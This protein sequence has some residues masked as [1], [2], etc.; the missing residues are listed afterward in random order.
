MKL[1]ALRPAAIGVLG[2]AVFFGAVVALTWSSSSSNI[3]ASA[4][5]PTPTPTPS[6]NAVAKVIS[7][8]GDLIGGALSRGRLGD[9]L[10]ANTG[11]QFV[12]QQP[13][14]NLLSVGQFG[15]QIID[16]DLVRALGDPERDSFE[17]FA[18]GI[19]IENTAHYTNVSI[20]N[21]G[22][23]GQPAIVRA[24]GVDDLLDFINPS[25]QA[26]DFGLT[27][28]AQFNDVDLPV[29]ITTD[30]I[31]APKSNYVEV[32]T[33]V[34]NT[35]TTQTVETFFTEF[36]NG[37]GDLEIFQPG[38]G[39]GEVLVSLACGQCNVLAWNGE[40]DATGVAYGYI[41]PLPE[42]TSF[43]TS[44][45]TI[46]AL[47][48]NAI[49]AL[50][51]TA[52]PNFDIP[53]LGQVSVTRYFAVSD[54]LGSIIDARNQITGATTGTI[55]GTITK[56][57]SPVEG[58][59]VTVLGNPVDGPGT[60]KNVVA[61]YRTD[62]SGNYQGTLPP[63]S[64]TVLAN[65]D[66][67]LDP[68]PNPG[69]V[70]IVASSTSTQNFAVPD[71]GRIKVLIDDEASNPLAGKVSII[72]FDPNPDPGNSQPSLGINTAI[73]GEIFQDSL[74]YGLADVV[75]V[76]HSG[77]SGEMFLE[78]GSYRIVVSHGTEYS[79]YEEDITV[80]AGSLTTVNAQ[81]ARVIDTTGFVSGDF[82]VHQLDSPDSEVS[83]R[84]RIVSMLAEG[85]DFFTPSD[86]DHRSDLAPAIAAMGAGGL[87]SVA[88]NSE[89]T[90]ADYG[91]F[92][93]WPL[94]I[95]PSKV[96]GG[97]ID[98]AKEAP[99]GMDFPGYGNYAA[100]PSEIFD[101]LLADPGVDTVQ[102]NHIDSF[103]GPSG[104]TI[105]TAYEPP[106]DFADNLSRRL[107]PGIPNL[108]DDS[109]TALESWQGSDRNDTLTRFVGR[110]MGDW[111]NLLNQGIVRSSIADS[112]TH[113]TIPSQAGFPRTMVASPTDDASMLDDIADTLAGN[114]NSGHATG[115]NGPFVKVTSAAASTGQSGGLGHGQAKLITT[116]NGNATIN[117]H[118]ESPLWAEFDRVEFY[119]NTIP[120]IDDYDSD[121]ST[122]PFYNVAPA[123]VQ[124]AG[125]NFTVN[126]INDFP[127]IPGAQHLE[128]D[129]SLNLSGLTEDTWIVVLVRGSDNVSEPLFPVLPNNLSS[130][131]N[132]TL[133]DLIDGNLGESGVTAMA[134]TN[135][136]FIDA[137]GNATYDNRDVDTDGDGCT[138]AQEVGPNEVDGG[139]RSPSNPN[140]YFNPTGDKLNRI[141]DILAVLGQYFDDDS[142]GNPGLPPYAPGYNPDTDRTDDPAYPNTGV[143]AQ[144]WRLLGGNGLQRIDDILAQVKQYFHDCA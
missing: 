59:D 61:H 26:Q 82:H 79:I 112:D 132:P 62:A 115:T 87:I 76:D 78:P 67:H 55:D 20:V 57:G 51:G 124:T 100:P 97:A 33:T 65:V 29:Q 90:T 83:Y 92:N 105:D 28:P 63:G 136:L 144:P 53:P 35:S 24:T 103:F 75:F 84:E 134:F 140:D 50:L 16:A 99:P 96:N 74:P 131:S 21:D 56:S 25:T 107:D 19:N 129:T 142:D 98:W 6:N 109:F 91:H 38:Y 27:I 39:F 58:A 4:G 17:E 118:V 40:G 72:G 32:E 13:Q 85:V 116:T 110:N 126:T 80:T 44:G 71:T 30:Y 52:D 111:F 81:I 88:V 139:K 104:L 133:A 137:N 89:T 60:T 34:Q 37:S 113:A 14:R 54:D 86:H 1:R 12:I 49:G 69:N 23:N 8:A 102:I 70:T 141:D 127:S 106:Q 138:N 64:Y 121:V 48:V 130:S 10:L 31:L 114:V 95:D 2:L 143:G 22:S 3:P 119:V 15:G 42:S 135:P 77:D 9:V 122:P 68:S 108:F 7:D 45:V 46:A 93:A 101:A 11:V 18:F 120:T 128:A 94:T 43:T 5:V 125:T 41:Y 66:G 47:G 117:V 73:F 36:I 123:V